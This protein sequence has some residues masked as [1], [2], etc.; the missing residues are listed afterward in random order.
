MQPAGRKV[1]RVDYIG[2]ICMSINVRLFHF[3]DQSFTYFKKK[4][5]GLPAVFPGIYTAFSNCYRGF[6]LFMRTIHFV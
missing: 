1:G 3:S 6:R 4:S 2:T 5:A